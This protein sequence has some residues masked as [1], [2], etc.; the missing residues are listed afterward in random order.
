MLICKHH[1]VVLIQ[2]VEFNAVGGRVGSQG[3]CD[4]SAGDAYSWTHHPI[5]GVSRDQNLPY[6]LFCTYR[7]YEIFTVIFNLFPKII[8]ISLPIYSVI[9]KKKLIEMKE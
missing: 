9:V 6:S 7:I 8:N 4:Q 1:H 3:G 2:F 5:S